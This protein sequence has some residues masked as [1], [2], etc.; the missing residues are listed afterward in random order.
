MATLGFI[1]PFKSETVS[2]VTI[3]IGAGEYRYPNLNKWYVDIFDS[4]FLHLAARIAGTHAI[5]YKDLYIPRIWEDLFHIGSNQKAF[6]DLLLK[7]DY[8]IPNIKLTGYSSYRII[9][10]RNLRAG[11]KVVQSEI[12]IPE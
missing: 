12:G 2:P 3:M 11:A 9:A 8:P 5:H 10:T 1:Y 6:E 4:V 7:L